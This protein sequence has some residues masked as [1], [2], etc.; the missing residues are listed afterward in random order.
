MG[1]PR[2]ERVE[3][4]M[5]IDSMP[6]GQA[7]DQLVAQQVM[8]EPLGAEAYPTWWVKAAGDSNR[9]WSPSG[10]D[11]AA[12]RVI[13]A[14]WTR[15]GLSFAHERDQTGHIAYFALSAKNQ[16]VV[17]AAGRAE[18]FALAVCRAALKAAQSS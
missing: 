14:V 3:L 1:N 4:R 2:T 17:K 10:Q 5:D 13:A 8:G 11:S 15:F 16:S 6:A 9:P 18:T 7:M 12:Y